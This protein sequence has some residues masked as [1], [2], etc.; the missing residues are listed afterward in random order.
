MIILV[1]DDTVLEREQLIVVVKNLGYDITFIA[2]NERAIPLFLEKKPTLILLDIEAHQKNQFKFIKEIR[3][4][5]TVEWTPIVFISDTINDTSIIEGIAAGADDYLTIPITEHG[6]AQKITAMNRLA[7]LQKKLC[8]ARSQ[9]STLS[10]HDPLTGI[11]NRLQ[12]DR[13]FKQCLTEARHHKTQMALLFINLDNFK[14]INDHMGRALGDKLLIDITKRLKRCLKQG[15]FLAR[16]GGDEF[17]VLLPFIHHPQEASHVA[18]TILNVF[19]PLY[20]VTSRNL[21]VSC[22]IGISCY[23]ASS[24]RQEV[25]LQGANAAM[26]TAKKLG[27]NNFQHCPDGFGK[28]RTQLFSLENALRF[29]LDNHELF[30]CYQPIYQLETKTLVGM[31]ALMRWKHPALGT[32]MPD[33]FIPIAEDMG[34]ITNIGN[35]ALRNVC[36]QAGRW[37]KQGHTHFKLAI[38]ISSRQL[39]HK[40]LLSF[41]KQLLKDT[42]LP[43]QLLEFEL[44][45]STVMSSSSSIDKIIDELSHMNIG[46]SLD[47][48]GTGYSSLSHIKRLPITAL[49]I[50]RS[51]VMDI[52]KDKNDDLIIAS[53]ISLGNILKLNL[54]AEGIESAEQL[55]FLIKNQC[56]YGQGYYF[57]KPL[58]VNAMGALLQQSDRKGRS[59]YH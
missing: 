18:Q 57:S 35:W 42:A 13:V 6:L 3:A 29:A 58:T 45:E 7:A 48:F 36:E 47:D 12:F 40:E 53:I 8:D 9:L 49:K 20:R 38:N 23:P 32:I 44:T 16:L 15:E 1:A 14:D 5:D 43:P 30:M 50:D 51:F 59:S 21:Y 46:I 11:P 31:E 34:L 37:Y 4:L 26:C 33:V 55:Q 25:L 28:H 17:A 2:I 56:P 52:H 54:I 41:V 19:K 27:R 10:T 22:S 39:L 24:S